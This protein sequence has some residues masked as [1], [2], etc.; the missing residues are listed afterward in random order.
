MSEETDIV[1]VEWNPPDCGDPKCKKSH[2][3][4]GSH[5]SSDPKI[6]MA[7]MREEGRVGAQFGK[8]G[9]RPRK[10]RAA[11]MIAEKVRQ[12]ADD[13]WKAFQNALESDNPKLALEAAQALLKVERDEA[14]QQLAEEEFDKMSSQELVS[15]LQE[16]LADPMVVEALGFSFE[17]IITLAPEEYAELT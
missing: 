6:R 1:P 5:Y 13:V 8:L 15:A 9:G 4:D 17:D 2:R 10:P 11:A 7:Q 14:Q 12:N 3:A 16:A